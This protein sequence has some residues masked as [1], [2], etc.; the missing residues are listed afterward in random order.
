VQNAQTGDLLRK[1]VVEAG[2]DPRNFVLYAF[3]GAGPA[4]CASYA[5]EVGVHEVVVPLGAVASAFSAFGLAASDIVL[6]AE[7]SDPTFVPFDPDRAEQIFVDLEKH[8]LKALDRQGVRYERV[9]LEREIDMRYSMQ[10]A[11]VTTPVASG[12]LDTAAIEAAAAAFE[13]RYAALYGKDAGFR[14]AGIQAITFRVRGTG[15]LPFSP[16]LPSIP[17]VDSPDPAAAQVNSRPVCLDA[18]AG[19]VDTPI[20]DYRGLRAGHVLVGP[21]IVEV[22]T[23]TV[24]VPGGTAGTVDTLGNLLIR[25]VVIESAGSPS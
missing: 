5:A 24:V 17:T 11:E 14:E 20:Y 19:Y 1:T 25:P 22:P 23:T 6:A 13:E 7:L 18:A 21:A 3:G 8:V 2:H 12:P 4:H 10:L 15:V 9:G 16:A